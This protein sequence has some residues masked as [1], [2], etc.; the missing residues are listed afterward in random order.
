MQDSFFTLQTL[1]TVLSLRISDSS[2]HEEEFSRITELCQ[3]FDRRYSRFIPGN[4]LDTL[5]AHGG[6]EVDDVLE[7]MLSF[8]LELARLSDGYFDPTI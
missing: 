7:D 3:S 2:S 8:A 5:N 1:G 4:Y 6:G